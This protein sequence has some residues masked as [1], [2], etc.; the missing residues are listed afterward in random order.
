MSLVATHSLRTR[1][2]WYLLLS[3]I[4]AAIAQ[5][6]IAYRTALSE[7]D[8]IFDY[9]MRQM[10]ISLRPGLP[11]GSNPDSLSPEVDDNFDFVVQV[12]TSN[13]SVVFRST[14][15]AEL[16]QRAVLGFSNVEARGTTYRIFSVEAG[17]QVIQVAQDLAVRRQM[18]IDLALRTVGPIGLMA[19]LLMLVVWFVISRSLAP[20]SRVRQQLAARQAAD[21]SEIHD[22]NL[23]EEVFPVVRELNLLF[24]RVRHAFDAQKSFVV[25]AA[26][27]LRSPLAA[28]KLQVL[29]MCRAKDAASREVAATRLNAGIDR[30]TRLIEQL[31]ML[32]RQQAGT[33]TGEV[34]VPVPLAK[35]AQEMVTEN[36]GAANERGIYLAVARCDGCTV[37][38]Q[39]DTLRILIRN[40]LD[41]AIKYTPSGGRVNVSVQEINGHP[42]LTVEDSGPGIA[43]EDRDRV[44]D[45]FFRVSGSLGSGSGLGLA[46]VKTIADLHHAT[47]AAS[48]SAELGGLVVTVTFKAA[49]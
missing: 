49:S 45:R 48:T 36:A 5:A 12:W 33:E 29:G 7:T 47:L 13:G 22:E 18:A 24:G 14:T 1:L 10:A 31:L 11:V 43:E 2:L 25:D 3:I 35:L 41:N 17:T 15:H 26:H 34:P 37:S 20:L 32:A 21:L 23:P 39:E 9:Q 8:Q 19:P 6:A 28:L 30:A 4:L 44:F 42:V 40:L 27:E 38:G 46:I 16:P